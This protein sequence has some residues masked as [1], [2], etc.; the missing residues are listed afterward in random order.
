MPRKLT[1]AAKRVEAAIDHLEEATAAAGSR[2]QHGLSDTA[3]AIGSSSVVE[4]VEK[5]ART[6]RK[7]IAKEI[8]KAKK[9]GKKQVATATKRVGVAKKA[10]EKAAKKQVATVTK[11]AGVAKKAAKKQVATATKRVGVAKKVA[12]KRTTNR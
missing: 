6:S 1:R 2:V 5:Q 10:T 8:A 11:K 7:A 12:K 4:R 9:V 3:A